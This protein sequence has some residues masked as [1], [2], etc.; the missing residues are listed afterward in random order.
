M[1]KAQGT[2][3]KKMEFRT[4]KEALDHYNKGELKM[5]ELRNAYGN[6]IKGVPV[7]LPEIPGNKGHTNIFYTD[8]AGRSLILE[9]GTKKSQKK[10]PDM[11][12][13]YV[14]TREKNGNGKNKKTAYTS[15]GEYKQVLF[16]RNHAFTVHVEVPSSKK[17]VPQEDILWDNSFVPSEKEAK[18][19]IDELYKEAVKI[20]EQR[21]KE[22]CKE[23]LT[24]KKGKRTMGREK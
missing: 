14:F 6:T 2:K 11:K 23:Q 8:K 15:K 5:P 17:R 21:A 12:T 22:Q 4:I 16:D 9:I 1:S 13:S 24:E 10:S 20:I 18:K 19:K 3:V 7:W